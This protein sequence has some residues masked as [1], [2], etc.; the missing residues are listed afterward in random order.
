M[1]IELPDADLSIHGDASRLCLDWATLFATS[2]MQ[3]QQ[4]QAQA[5]VCW[6]TAMMK[7]GTEAWDEWQCRFAGGVPIDG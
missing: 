1:A 3:A 4:L 6:Q 2:M 7:I 5:L